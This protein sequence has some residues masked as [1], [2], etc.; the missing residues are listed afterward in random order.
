M[1]RIGKTLAF[2]VMLAIAIPSCLFG[3]GKADTPAQ[4]PTNQASPAPKPAAGPK[5]GGTM[6]GAMMVKITSM[7]PLNGNS[8]VGEGC[9]YLAIYNRLLRKD[10]AGNLVPELAKSWTVSPDGK[11]VTFELQ[12]GVTF[13]DGTPFNAQAVK[14]NYDRLLN[15][16]DA[17]TAY[18]YFTDVDSFE[19]VGDYRFV[20]N[21]KRP[22]AVVMDALTYRGGFIVSPTAFKKLGADFAQTPVGTGPFKLTQFIPDNRVVLVRNENYWEMGA[23]GKKLPY[24]DQVVLR[25]I[26][27]DSVRLVEI[28]S[29]N[30]DLS[31][32]V[33][34][35]S[36]EIVRKDQKL[37]LVQTPIADVF[38]LF[39]NQRR[40]PFNNLKLR[41][42]VGYA[43]D[44]AAMAQA[45]VPGQGYVAPFLI[46][47]GEAYYSPY[48]PFSYNVAK[49]KQLLAE[50]GYPNGLDVGF[51]MISR[52]PDNTIAPV[53]QSYLA[54]IGIRTKIE[55]LERQVY[56]DRGIKG[57]FD[58]ALAQ[59]TIP[60]VSPFLLFAEQLASKGSGNRA[61]W[62]NA[63]FD[64]L[65]S[66]LGA[67]FDLPQQKSLIA[68][69]Q[70]IHLDDAGQTY[71]FHRANYNANSRKV[72]NVQ[73][74]NEGAWRFTEA[75]LDN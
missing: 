32:R 52:E 36:M 24:L 57:E 70:K 68:E 33:P 37:E 71:L 60:M 14:F 53:V 75:W 21:L 2:V 10:E 64:E 61:A 45:I 42:A 55:P 12:Q 39:L 54:A 19:A 38:R 43:F 13:H 46:M 9:V 72:R 22:S 29:G 20:M 69:M 26:T 16:K 67:A 6:T 62:S 50:A 5:R 15:P 58:L 56:V 65:L 18:Q 47:P 30:A 7:D 34:A 11:S 25:I 31:V 40:P 35:E 1:N 48:D 44:R 74:Q 23:D 27:D 63:R 4:Q 28:Q 17:T 41:Q 66:R 3:S 59:K 73:F 51:M 8:F 49:A